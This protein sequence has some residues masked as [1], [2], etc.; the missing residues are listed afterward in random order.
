MNT[1]IFHLVFVVVVVAVFLSFQQ[2]LIFGF[3]PYIAIVLIN[4]F[5]GV[6]V[7]NWRKFGFF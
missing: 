1:N 3:Q 7:T 2:I 4:I 6:V 5:S